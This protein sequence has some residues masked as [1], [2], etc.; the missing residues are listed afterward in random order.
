MSELFTVNIDQDPKGHPNPSFS[1]TS[2]I[3][4][5]H[6]K[7]NPMFEWRESRGEGPLAF[8][9]SLLLSYLI[10]FYSKHTLKLNS[11]RTKASK[12]VRIQVYKNAF[13]RMSH[14]RKSLKE[15]SFLCQQN[16]TGLPV[17]VSSIPSIFM[18]ENWNWP[19]MTARYLS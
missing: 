10:S 19:S 4:N 14:I 5:N 16:E 3:Q 15:N 13:M 11:R 1:L 17:L 7:I 9:S 8:I 6:K 2:H 18:L 12:M